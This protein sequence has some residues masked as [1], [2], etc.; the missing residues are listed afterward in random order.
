MGKLIKKNKLKIFWSFSGNDLNHIFPLNYKFIFCFYKFF[1]LI[2]FTLL[3]LII[4]KIFPIF[5]SIA[6]NKG[7]FLFVGTKYVYSQSICKNSFISKLENLDAGILTN[8]SVKG[9]NHFENLKLYKNV[10]IILFFYI[11]KND[12]LLLESKRKD[13]PTIGLVNSFTNISLIDYPIFLNSSYFY[14]TY[15]F[16]RFFF[17]YILALI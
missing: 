9:F 6:L 11:L 3:I 4:K 16:S 8:F 10:S 12:Y 1:F 13:I 14:N 17:K 7:K 2:D 5:L 15:I